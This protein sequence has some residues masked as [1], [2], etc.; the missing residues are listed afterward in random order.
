MKMEITKQPQTEVEY[1]KAIEGLGGYFWS[2]NHGLCHG[3]IED[4]DGEVAKSIEDARKISERLAVE[5]GEK[6]GVIHPRACPFSEGLQPMIALGG[7]VPCGIFPGMLYKL[8]APY[9]CYMLWAEG[10]NTEKLY[11]KIVMKA[12]WYALMQ[13][14]KKE[15]EIRDNLA[16]KP[17]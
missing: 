6:F 1:W 4:K 2:T 14:Q 3:H 11:E 12:G 13:F 15:K 10:W 17:Q 16:Q 9:E 5:L 8:I 7:V